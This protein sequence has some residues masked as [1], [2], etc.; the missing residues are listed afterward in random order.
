MKRIAFD[1]FYLDYKN[2]HDFRKTFVLQ[3]SLIAF[4]SED[5]NNDV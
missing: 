3:L 5:A 2:T 1:L 4:D